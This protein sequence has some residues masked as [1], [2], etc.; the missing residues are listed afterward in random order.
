[1]V[2]VV[3][4]VVV[5]V[6]GVYRARS[7]DRGDVSPVTAW[8][9]SPSYLVLALGAAVG[10][11]ALAAY[12]IGVARDRLASG[13]EWEAILAIVGVIFGSAF[14]LIGAISLVLGI[15]LWTGRLTR[16]ASWWFP[17]ARSGASRNE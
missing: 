6:Y 12:L 9:P 1:M 17:L 14:G 4:G 2:S 7:I 11:V 5:L 16:A 15:G 8:K 10:G 13:A 3:L